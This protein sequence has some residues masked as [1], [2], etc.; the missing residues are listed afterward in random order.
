MK[1]KKLIAAAAAILSALLIAGCSGEKSKDSNKLTQLDQLQQNTFYVC[2]EGVYEP[3][4]LNDSS[5]AL[6]NFPEKADD[7]CTLF[8]TDDYEKIPTFYSGD[9]L[10]YCTGAV[11]DEDFDFMRWEDIG[12]SFGISGLKETP[13]GR[14]SV[15]TSEKSLLVNEHSDASKLKDLGATSVI[16]DKVG[17]QYIRSGNI[18]RGGVIISKGGSLERDQDYEMEAYVGTYMNRIYIKADTRCM[19]SMEA[20]VVN[21]YTF[22][23]S[24]ILELHIPDW[25]KT[26]YYSVDG[27]GVFRYIDGQSYTENTDFN[28]RNEI[29]AYSERY[30]D[31]EYDVDIAE[32]GRYKLT[33]KY[34]KSGTAVAP[35]VQLTGDTETYDLPVTDIGKMEGEYVLLPGT[36]KLTA[37]G[38]EDRTFTYAVEMLEEL[39]EEGAAPTETA[40]EDAAEA[41]DVP[42]YDMN[43]VMQ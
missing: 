36:Y 11:L 42:D 22:L 19:T 32:Y 30:S 34:T 16:I 23:Q 38:M 24:N 15:S 17:M 26:G 10:L 6:K 4:Y 9:Q 37:S 41:D 2:H 33:V 8:F 25:M 40:T 35:K 28:A 5:F 13:S 29:E 14:Y 12:W 21:D 43:E 31:G 20:F 7:N 27:M 39:T 18:T 3:L 1:L